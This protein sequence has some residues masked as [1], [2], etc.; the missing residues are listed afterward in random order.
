MNKD[1][2]LELLLALL[3]NVIYSTRL[4]PEIVDIIAKNGQELNFAKTLAIRLRMLSMLG[5]QATQAKTFEPIRDGIYSMHLDNKIYNI[6][7]LYAFLPSQQ[8]ALLLAFY[9]RGG[10]SKTDYSPYI[11]PAK[12]RLEELIGAM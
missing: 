7:I 3:G 11:E 9:E 10:K 8:P 6:R 12:A 4:V 5:V 1:D 2:V